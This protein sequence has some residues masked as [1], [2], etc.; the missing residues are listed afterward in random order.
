MAVV[1]SKGWFCVGKVI[2]PCAYA[3]LVRSL[4][5]LH[6]LRFDIVT[7]AELGEVYFFFTVVRGC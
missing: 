5:R 2:C 3:S 7:R 1:L 4:K 6:V